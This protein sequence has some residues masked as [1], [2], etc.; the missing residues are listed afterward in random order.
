VAKQ[1]KG[2]YASVPEK[3]VDCRPPVEQKRI[4]TSAEALLEL[5]YRLNTFLRA[6]EEN[7]PVE[8][9]AERILGLGRPRAYALLREIDECGDLEA[10]FRQKALDGMR[11]GRIR[12]GRETQSSPIAD[13]FFVALAGGKP[14][15][16]SCVLSLAGTTRADLPSEPDDEQNE[17]VSEVRDYMVHSRLLWR[18]DADG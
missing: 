13:A 18:I 17:A 11:R 3:V 4:T 2:P 1:P 8:W 7:A 15:A 16:K 9:A 10:W 14:E 12:R 6:T 5:Y